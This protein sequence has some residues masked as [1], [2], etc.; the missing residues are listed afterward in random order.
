MRDLHDLRTSSSPASRLALAVGVLCSFLL[1]A[2]GPKGAEGPD[3]ASRTTT[4]SSGNAYPKV[5]LIGLDG[6]TW[7]VLD[8]LLKQGRLPNFQ[9]LMDGGVRADLESIAP[10][11]SPMIWTTVATGW[12][13][14]HHGIF[15]FNVGET[16]VT[17]NMRQKKALWNIASEEGK[18]VGVVAYWVTWPAEE[19]NGYIV[20]ERAYFGGTMEHQTYPD[21]VLDGYGEFWAWKED[22]P[23]ND[24]RMKRFFRDFDFDSAY[25]KPIKSD[26]KKLDEM[27]AAYRENPKD[28]GRFMAHFLIDNRLRFFFPKDESVARLTKH[29]M[30]ERPTDLTMTYLQGID[31]CSHGF[32]KFYR[33]GNYDVPESEVHQLGQ[34]IPRYCEYV[35]EKIGQILESVDD[36]TVVIICSDHGF[37]DWHPGNDDPYW[38]LSGNHKSNGILLMKGPHVKQG[39]V[40][41]DAHVLD[42]APTILYL[43]G[44]QVGADMEGRVLSN[45]LDTQF[46]ASNPIFYVPSYEGSGPRGDTAP[47]M[48]PTDEQE[49]ERLRA[50]GYI[51]PKEGN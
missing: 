20:T 36:D 46:L 16:P 22:S 43:L 35:D 5:L 28:N 40:L 11:K 17:S 37:Q 2:C 51:A 31:I 10:Y 4:A 39:V 29:L 25:Y 3:P 15:D 45:A 32:W 9:R 44:L 34:I 27:L 18:S 12:D 6:T 23:E 14:T 41:K 38:Y 47:I 19:V 8:P 7:E 50:L 24:R 1:S 49:M 48:S 42:V 30:R 33:P 26:K 13:W 21:N